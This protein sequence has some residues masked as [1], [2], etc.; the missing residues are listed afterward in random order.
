MK[1]HDSLTSAKAVLS[2]FIL[3]IAFVVFYKFMANQEYFFED[4]EMLRNYVMFAIVG[5]GFMVGLL[6]LASQTKHS[7]SKNTTKKSPTSKKKKR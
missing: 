5:G 4:I 7:V 6:Y 2:L 1:I 3:L